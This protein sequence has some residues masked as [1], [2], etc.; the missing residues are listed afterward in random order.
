MT[1]RIFKPRT[2]TQ[3]MNFENTCRS[4]QI[5]NN[6]EILSAW[7]AINQGELIQI[8]PCSFRIYE[9]IVIKQVSI[10]SG[11]NDSIEVYAELEVKVPSPSL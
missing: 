10:I 8:E 1:K 4:I 7:F 9:N 2:Y 5:C 11:F 3:F 6:D